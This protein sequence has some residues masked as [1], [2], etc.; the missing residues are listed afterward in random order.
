VLVRDFK[1]KLDLP[2]NSFPVLSFK[3]RK[4]ILKH[5]ESIGVPIEINSEKKRDLAI[6]D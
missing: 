6:L 4:A 1:T 5:F 2:F 3:K